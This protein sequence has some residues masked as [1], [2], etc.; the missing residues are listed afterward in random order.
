MAL[1][2]LIEDEAMLRGSMARG[3][4]RLPGVEVAEAGSL[5]EALA[6]RA[7]DDAW[8]APFAPMPPKT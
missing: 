3:L 7:Q 2:L 8:L 5:E 1:V 4:A 6:L